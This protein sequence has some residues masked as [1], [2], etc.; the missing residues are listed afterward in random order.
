MVIGYYIALLSWAKQF[1]IHCDY[2]EEFLFQVSIRDSLN[3]RLYGFKEGFNYSKYQMRPVSNE[4]DT[5]IAIPKAISTRDLN[6]EKILKLAKDV[7]NK[8]HRAFGHKYDYLFE[9]SK[10]PSKK[11]QEFDL[12]G[13]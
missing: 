11:I 9:N 2:R 13:F 6:Y 8:L 3:A 10:Y 12:Y 5:N 4:Y 1:Y 7:S